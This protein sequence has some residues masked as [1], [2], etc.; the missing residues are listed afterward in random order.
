MTKLSHLDEHGSARMVD[1]SGKDVTARQAC[2]EAVI[3]MSEQAYSA[4]IKGDG[5]K[6]D[7]LSTARIAGI[8]AIKRTSDLIPLCHPL[9]ISNAAIEFEPLPKQYALRILATVKTNGQTGVEMEALMG[10]SIAALTVYD[11]IKAVDKASQ[12]GSIRVLTKSGGKSGTYS[13]PQVRNSRLS[14]GFLD[15]PARGLSKAIEPSHRPHIPTQAMGA[16]A[17]QAL[18]TFM[19]SHHL[20]ASQWAK[21]ANVPAAQIYGFLT[22]KTHTIAPETLSKL[23]AVAGVRPQDLLG[24][25]E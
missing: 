15:A 22:G 24:S 11:M 7:V 17:R 16:N 23:A 3:Q 2:A 13:V 6:G 18:R 12:I 20:R 21:D 5:P 25:L 19:T 10:A 14:S 4:A 9:A 1:V 8:M